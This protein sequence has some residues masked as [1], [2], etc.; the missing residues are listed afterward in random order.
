MRVS[1]LPFAL[2]A[3]L[4]S[5]AAAA[6]IRGSSSATHPA[7]ELKDGSSVVDNVRNLGT[8]SDNYSSKG[9]EEDSKGNPKDASDSESKS[10]EGSASK[11]GSKEKG[12][13]GSKGMDGESK[14]GYMPKGLTKGDVKGTGK[15]FK[16]EKKEKKGGDSKGEESSKKMT[17]TAKKMK[18]MHD[19]KD[20]QKMVKADSGT[21]KGDF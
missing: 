3:V 12:G 1:C 15:N 16:K 10:D 11:D 13:S 21:T 2:L 8:D 19:S 7:L 5:L 14:D 20:F 9:V 6:Q 4:A 17:K 18:K